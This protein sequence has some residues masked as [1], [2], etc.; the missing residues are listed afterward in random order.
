MGPTFVGARQAT[1]GQAPATVRQLEFLATL[2]KE[3]VVDEAL[4]G[5]IAFELEQPSGPSRKIVSELIDDLLKAPHTRSHQTLHGPKQNVLPDHLREIP[6]GRYAVDG[7]DGKLRFVKVD[8]PEDGA[9]AGWTFVS[10]QAGDEFHRLQ[11]DQANKALT[12]IH[13]AGARDASVRYGRELGQCGVCGR[14]LTDEN[15]RAAGI[16]PVCV[17][18]AG[19]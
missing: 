13:E 7:A 5:D 10:T 16:G 6:A 17:M 18:K 1:Y 11:H 2:R 9:W 8:R 3:R 19:W 4:A 15:S 12:R 14:T